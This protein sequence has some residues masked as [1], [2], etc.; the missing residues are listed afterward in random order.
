MIRILLNTGVIQLQEVILE[1]T[2]FDN[3][4]EELEWY[5]L[6]HPKE[7]TRYEAHEIPESEIFEPYLYLPVNGGEWYTNGII[8]IEEVK[9]DEE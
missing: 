1:C 2:I 8:A 3:V 5:I 9:L 4:L 7:F 6:E